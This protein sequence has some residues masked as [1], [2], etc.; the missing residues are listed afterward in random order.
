MIFVTYL[1]KKEGVEVVGGGRTSTTSTFF[2]FSCSFSRRA[3]MANYSGGRS[4][5]S[6]LD[7]NNTRIWH[8]PVFFIYSPQ[9]MMVNLSFCTL[10]RSFAL[11]NLF[12]FDFFLLAG[13]SVDNNNH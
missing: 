5:H 3:I 8:D 4:D 13:I 7:L 6:T 1:R 9:K 11:F 2:R 10:D 12:Q